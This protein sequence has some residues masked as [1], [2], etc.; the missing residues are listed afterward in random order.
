MTVKLSEQLG[1]MAQE[2][3]NNM[4][5]DA[6]AEL[7]RSI[8]ELRQSE[9]VNGLPTGVDAPDFTLTDATGEFITLSQEIDKGPVVLTFYRGAWCPFCNLQLRAYQSAIPYLEEVGATLIAVSP[10]VPDY[11]LLQ[12]QQNLLTFPVLSDL[13]GHVA[14][15]YKVRYEVSQ[16]VVRVMQGIG[17]DLVQYNETAQW[18]LPVPAT[19]IIDQNRTI[20]FSHVDPNFMMRLDPD[21]IVQVLKE[22]QPRNHRSP[23]PE[24]KEIRR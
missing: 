22:M 6:Q 20:R 1:S 7:W 21:I 14:A 8:E 4:P 12:Q 11:T 2:L 19:F 23:L 16:S 13:Q 5:S 15:L 3:A 24:D 17:I 9:D 18:T 10:Q